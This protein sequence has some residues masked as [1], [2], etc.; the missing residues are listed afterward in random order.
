MTD[1][2][3]I[4]VRVLA[5][6]D[7]IRLPVRNWRGYT[8]A[9]RYFATVAGGAVPYRVSNASE[10]GR[11]ASERLLQDLA[12]EGM[13]T[14][15]RGQKVKFPLVALTELGEARTR[16]LCGL[17]GRRV[18]RL[19]LAEVAK[20]GERYVDTESGRWVPEIDL[21][22]GKGWDG[23]ESTSEDRRGLAQVEMNYL[24]AVAAGWLACDSD[25]YGHVCYAATP[26]GLDELSRRPKRGPSK[27]PET[28]P[29]AVRAYRKWQD[30]KLLALDRTA[31]TETREIGPLPM[32]ASLVGMTQAE[33]DEIEAAEPSS[34]GH[35][36][37]TE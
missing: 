13:L 12:A 5:D 7:A 22:D 3:A 33:F 19:M 29:D 8:S 18:G 16:A 17:V 37:P 26:A 9:N 35:E 34:A 2:E 31:P 10:A 11:K 6:Q 20:R 4:L 32:I 1:S 25:V 28:D 36:T 24:P 27:L 15:S 14:V 21:N 23:D 30:A